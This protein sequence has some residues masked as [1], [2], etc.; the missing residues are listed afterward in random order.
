MSWRTKIGD[1][2][3]FY[4]EH[5]QY[6]A[7]SMIHITTELTCK[8]WWIIDCLMWFTFHSFNRIVFKPNLYPPCKVWWLWFWTCASYQMRKI[9]G[10]ARVG[11]AGKVVVCYT[12]MHQGMCVTHVTWCKLGSLTSGFPWS[13]WRGKHSWHFPAHAQP[14]IMGI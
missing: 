14:T 11:Y 5:E 2:A 8:C 13:R 12:D 3:C 1:G 7:K 4:Q 10:C 9:A 6:P